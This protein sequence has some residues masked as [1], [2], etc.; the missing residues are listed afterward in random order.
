MKQGVLVTSAVAELNTDSEK[1]QQELLELIAT[2]GSSLDNISSVGRLWVF[3][4]AALMEATNRL[5]K[6][7]WIPGK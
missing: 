3:A 1:R 5:D 2:E 6:I 4:T 7:R